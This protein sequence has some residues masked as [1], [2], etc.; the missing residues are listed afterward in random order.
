MVEHLNA[1]IEVVLFNKVF[2]NKSKFYLL[3]QLAVG[4]QKNI[5]RLPTI[6]KQFYL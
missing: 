1:K 2:I 3:Q 5:L 4:L 6:L